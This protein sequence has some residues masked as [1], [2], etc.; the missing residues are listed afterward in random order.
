MKSLDP[1]SALVGA[2]LG[3][4]GMMFIAQRPV[5]SA[6]ARPAAA[7][8]DLQ[9]TGSDNRVWV[10]DRT[11]GDLTTYRVLEQSLRPDPQHAAN[12]YRQ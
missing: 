11:T 4:L 5:G 10:F 12:L 2:L 7:H 3:A 9:V 8:H 1:K 6:I